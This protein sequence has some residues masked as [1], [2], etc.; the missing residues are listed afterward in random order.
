MSRED[1]IDNNDEN[2]TSGTSNASISIASTLI[3]DDDT[4]KNI[5]KLNYQQREV[6]KSHQQL[7]RLKNQ[8]KSSHFIYF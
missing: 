2:E 5:R 4:N 8:L 3:P 7:F 1:D 6:F